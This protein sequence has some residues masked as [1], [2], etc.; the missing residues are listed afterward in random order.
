M[1]TS[2]LLIISHFVFDWVLQPRHIAK[3]KGNTTEG[4]QAVVQ[5]MILNIIPFSLVLCLIFLFSD[6]S[7][8]Y[9][10]S[11]IALNF[12]SHFLIDVYLPKGKTDRAMVN[13]NALD[14]IL[15]LSILFYILG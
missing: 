3:A 6:Y 1:I 2:I 11:A 15:H 5:H 13:W 4:I 10:T 12:V 14:Q 9:I 7:A 8:Y